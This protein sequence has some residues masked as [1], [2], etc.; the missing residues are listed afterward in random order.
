MLP[1]YFFVLLIRQESKTVLLKDSS[2]IQL[3]HLLVWKISGH[4]LISLTRA[5]CVRWTASWDSF[6][7]I[8]FF[9]SLKLQATRKS[10]ELWS[11]K[12]SFQSFHGFFPW[13]VLFL[14]FVYADSV[15]TF[16]LILSSKNFM[17]IS[18]KNCKCPI[19]TFHN[20]DV[21]NAIFI[22]I[23]NSTQIWKKLRRKE[24]MPG[25]EILYEWLLYK[26][27]IITGYMKY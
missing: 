20:I 3:F 5:Y 6:W 10:V 24:E 17:F 15:I 13:T 7:K 21:R 12:I 4:R 22:Y 27:P 8:K 14:V 19:C 2:S 25:V 1:S 16:F 9:L 23:C 26:K 18:T 11:N